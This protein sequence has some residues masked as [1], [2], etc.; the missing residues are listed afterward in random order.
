V[1]VYSSTSD[2]GYEL[3][4]LVVQ[5]S[6]IGIT[7]SALFKASPSRWDNGSGVTVALYGGAVSS[8]DMSEVLNGANVAAIG[9]GTSGNWEVFQFADAELLVSGE[10]QLSTLLRGQA[11]SEAIMPDDWPVGSYVVMLDGV[12]GQIDLVSSARDL[13][14]HYRIGPAPRDVSDSSYIHEI[15]AFSGNGLKPYAPAHLRG[16]LDVYGDR[17][18]SWIRRSRV[19]GDSWGANDVP[20]GET[21]EAYRLRVLDEIGALVRQVDL[22]A[23]TWAYSMAMQTADGITG[24]YS[25]EVAQISER[26]GAGSFARIEING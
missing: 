20:L 6:V 1:A 13:A 21:Y 11:G 10:Y 23:P 8:A 22:S 4:T 19:D 14:R 3:N 25:V 7:T 17:A 24:D 12:P 2:V 16:A 15:E 26:F 18:F 5:S 9:D